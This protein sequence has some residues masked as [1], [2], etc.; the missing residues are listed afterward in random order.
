MQIRVVK[1]RVEIWDEYGIRNYSIFPSENEARNYA[2]SINNG[3]CKSY[4]NC[5]A[6]IQ[7][8]EHYLCE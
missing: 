3:E 4:E 7:R 6:Y 8:I 1:Y 2:I 5:V